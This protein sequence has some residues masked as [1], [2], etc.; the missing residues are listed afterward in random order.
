[1]DPIEFLIFL[2]FVFNM[3]ILGALSYI[4]LRHREEHR[5]EVEELRYEVERLKRNF[6]LWYISNFR[7]YMKNYYHILRNIVKSVDEFDYYNI[8]I[9]YLVLWNSFVRSVIITTHLIGM[10]QITFNSKKNTSHNRK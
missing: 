7:I 5:K 4:T 8:E 1:M 6:T 10:S 9:G 3:C 2:M